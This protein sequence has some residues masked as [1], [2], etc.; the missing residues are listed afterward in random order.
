M[1]PTNDNEPPPS[2]AISFTDLAKAM[3]VDED[4]LMRRLANILNKREA[5]AQPG[6]GEGV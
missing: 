5:P 1:K 2:G 6:G 3:G 4:F